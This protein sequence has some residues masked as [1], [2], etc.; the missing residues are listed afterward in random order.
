MAP[1]L[2]LSLNRSRNVPCSLSFSKARSFS[3]LTNPMIHLK[4]NAQFSLCFCYFF[5]FKKGNVVQ[6]RLLGWH[7]IF[8]MHC[9]YPSFHRGR[10]CFFISS[11]I[12]SI[13]SQNEKVF[14]F[15]FSCNNNNNNKN[16]MNKKHNILRFSLP[17]LIEVNWLPC[18]IL[19]MELSSHWNSY[20][21]LRKAGKI[22]EVKRFSPPGFWEEILKKFL[23][24]SPNAVLKRCIN[25]LPY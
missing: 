5:A 19:S 1:S 11:K 4:I 18:R 21:D 24:S 9:S 14:S 23:Y 17:T 2:L 3:L 15:R 22:V 16:A 8:I 20:L 7:T 10:R 12:P 25:H 6:K 13:Q